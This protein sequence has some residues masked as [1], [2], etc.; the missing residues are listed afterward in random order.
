MASK[1]V[2]NVQ[3]AFLNQSRK[4]RTVLTVHMVDG[5]EIVGRITAFDNFTFALYD[6]KEQQQYLVYKHAIGFIEPAEVIR[7][8]NELLMTHREMEEMEGIA[9]S[10]SD[11]EDEDEDENFS[12]GEYGEGLL[13]SNT[14]EG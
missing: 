14:I 6:A 4:N 5:S 10:D 1:V 9:P 13:S 11:Y 2:L 12:G 7:Y 8:S 3:D